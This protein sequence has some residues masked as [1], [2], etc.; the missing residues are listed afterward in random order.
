MH[1]H[2]QE[3]DQPVYRVSLENLE[4]VAF[5]DNGGLGGKSDQRAV[6]LILPISTHSS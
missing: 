3:V 6:R 2:T 4:K 5:A 1:I